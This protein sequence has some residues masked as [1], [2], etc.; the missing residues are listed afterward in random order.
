MTILI[1]DGYKIMRE[2]MVRYLELKHLFSKV[3]QANTVRNAEMILRKEHIDIIILDL[4]LPD[5]SGI[6]LIT[7]CNTMKKKP[8]VIICSHYWM[9]Q[10]RNIYKNLSVDYFFDK[11]YQFAELKE[12][13]KKLSRTDYKGS[14][15]N[16]HSYMEGKRRML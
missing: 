14:Q 9:N 13:I 10:Y 7:Y 1:V 5:A 8:T 12:L 3:F 11:Y 6:D 16:S 2:T 15:K 4:Q